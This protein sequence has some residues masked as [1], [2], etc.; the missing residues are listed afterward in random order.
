MAISNV[1]SFIGSSAVSETGERW[2]TAARTAV[3]LPA[4]GW[5]S[6]LAGKST[7]ILV[8]ITASNHNFNTADLH[9][10]MLAAAGGTWP[11]TATWR[12]VVN[13]GVQLVCR[14]TGEQCM[15][16]GGGINGKV[17]I[18]NHGHILGRGGQGG[19]ITCGNE[20]C[21]NNGAAG[22]HA[23]Y[24]EAKITLEIRN[25]GIIG[26]GGGGG[27]SG[28]TFSSAGGGR[29]FGQGGG[30]GAP[31]GAGGYSSGP[32]HPRPG[33]GASYDTG[34][35]GG[36]GGDN[37]EAWGGTGGNIG[38]NGGGAWGNN[39]ANRGGG[40]AGYAIAG[41]GTII[42]TNRGDIRGAVS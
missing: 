24:R 41:G 42:W 6:E 15:W 22:G 16:F 34:A 20:S 8:T 12:I 32:N 2:M 30:G 33:G 19:W 7:E 35:R 37:R 23:I 27:G 28:Y 31:F 25:F 4:P 18:E 29:H 17:I 3:R 36:N 11:A 38:N 9:S 26:G 21:C 1:P 14:N 39:K 13:S 10:A 40:A 5:L